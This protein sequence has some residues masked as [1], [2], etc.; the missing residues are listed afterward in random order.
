[1]TAVYSLLLWRT[2]VPGPGSNAGPGP[3]T[4]FIWVVR[5]IDALFGAEGSGNACQVSDELFYSF[6]LLTTPSGQYASWRGRQIIEAGGS[7]NAT[8]LGSNHVTLRIS[9]YQLTLP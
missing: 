4:G 1:M 8:N 7:I 3:P 2:L 9:G 6:A 5:D